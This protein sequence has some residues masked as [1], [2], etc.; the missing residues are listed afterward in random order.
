MK[1]K[2]DAKRPHAKFYKWR[3]GGIYHLVFSTTRPIG[4]YWGNHR[5]EYGPYKTQEECECSVYKRDPHKEYSLSKKDE[6]YWNEVSKWVKYQKRITI[7][8][9]VRWNLG[10]GYSSET[11]MPSMRHIARVFP[12]SVWKH[13]L[14]KMTEYNP[15]TDE[16]ILSGK[17][18]LPPL[19]QLRENCPG[20]TE[21]I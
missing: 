12:E 7:E 3:K 1:G 21:Q 9:R 5:V 19:K 6:K 14:P 15:E 8:N 17:Y 4:W 11:D 20:I 16:F 13:F 18:I 2:D 10:K